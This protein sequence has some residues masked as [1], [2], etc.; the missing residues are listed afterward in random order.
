MFIFIPKYLYRVCFYLMVKSSK[1]F[2]KIVLVY[3]YTFSFYFIEISNPPLPRLFR[4]LNYLINV[5][6]QLPLP[7]LIR[8]PVHSR[9]KSTFIGMRVN[10]KPFKRILIWHFDRVVFG[11]LK[12]LDCVNLFSSLHYRF[13]YFFNCFSLSFFSFVFFKRRFWCLLHLISR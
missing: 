2:V 10:L 11:K 13:F 7:P 9:P 12:S 4:L 6:F 3:K 1:S 8:T 5:M